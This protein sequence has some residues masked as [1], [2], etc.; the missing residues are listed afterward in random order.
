MGCTCNAVLRACSAPGSSGPWGRREVVE[1]CE[2]A[3]LPR[4]WGPHWH[5]TAPT[6]C[7]RLGR[8]EN[9]QR[10]WDRS[11]VSIFFLKCKD[12]YVKSRGKVPALV[13][14]SPSKGC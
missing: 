13:L 8:S 7:S 6:A 14:V 10:L 4:L 5:G 3:L 1:G 12:V 2:A 9:R 11:A